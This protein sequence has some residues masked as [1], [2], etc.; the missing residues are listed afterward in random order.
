M[1]CST[2]DKVLDTRHYWRIA[3]GH[4]FRYFRIYRKTNR[5]E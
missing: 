4:G 3:G 2:W 1:A 5:K